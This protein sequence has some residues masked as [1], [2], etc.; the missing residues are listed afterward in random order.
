MNIPFNITS[1]SCKLWLPP[2]PGYNFNSNPL[3]DQWLGS[4]AAGI[5]NNGAVQYCGDNS[6]NDNTVTQ[7]TAASAPLLSQF[8]S[9]TESHEPAL[10]FRSISSQFLPIPA[11]VKMGDG[12]PASEGTLIICLRAQPANAG[13][14]WANGIGLWPTA[15]A[16]LGIFS[17][18]SNH[19]FPNPFMVNTFSPQVIAVRFKS[20]E[21][22]LFGDTNYT[23]TISTNFLSGTS[24]GGFIGSLTSSSFFADFDLYDFVIFDQAL[25]DADVLTVMQG[26]KDRVAPNEG[27]LGQVLAFGDSRTAGYNSGAGALSVSRSW[28]GRAKRALGGIGQWYS[29]AHVGDKIADQS[30]ALTTFLTLLKPSIYSK[31][32]VIGEVGVNDINAGSSAATVQSALT[33]LANQILAGGA[34]TAIF[35]TIAPGAAITGAAETVRQTVNAWLVAGGIPGITVINNA[36]DP[37]LTL[38]NYADPDGLHFLDPG[39]GVYSQNTAAILRPFLLGSA[40]AVNLNYGTF[41]AA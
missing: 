41:K 23:D 19:S 36:A 2:G 4:G 22:K 16:S 3:P 30:T 21:T 32:I 33:S 8:G 11:A 39:Y 13:F 29:S 37:R 18:G 31:R 6:D 40:N 38:P 24:T 5:A 10:R 34:T 28:P 7:S 15:T 1:A 12:S 9:I 14:F 20:G 35:L 26:M 25:S 27:L 17:S